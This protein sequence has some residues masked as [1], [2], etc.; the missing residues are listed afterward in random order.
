MAGPQSNARLRADAGSPTSG[1]IHLRTRLTADF[2]VIA[3]ALAQRRGSA[4]T[5]GV[6]AYILSLPDGAPVS[7]AA[8]CRHFTEGEI[9]ISRALREL[10]AAGYLERRRER[11][12]GGVIRTRTFFNDVPGDAEVS[13]VPG[14]GAL[15]RSR[16]VHPTPPTRSAPPPAARTPATRSTRFTQSTRSAQPP[17][18]SAPGPGP[19]PAV[20]PEPVD[21]PD[22]SLSH[23]APDPTPAAREREPLREREPAPESEPAP[24][25]D[26]VSRTDPRALVIL[27]SLRIRDPRLILSRREVD[28]LAPAVSLW[29]ARGVGQKEITDLLT[30]GLPDRFRARP[31]R[32][33]A[34]RLDDPPVAAPPPSTVVPDA[35]AK[36][37]VLPWQTCDG[38]CERAFRAAEPGCCRDCRSESVSPRAAFRGPLPTAC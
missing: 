23:P 4:V 33:L 2:T 35:P 8:L 1:V 5:V 37:V 14:R 19:V 26:P 34:Y 21:T 9:L 30:T 28:R 12:P 3:N 7:I 20:P 13:D 18:P 15:S 24:E 29:L 31:A 27:A 6:A 10:E 16:P 17:T 11:G 36:P 32:I 38:G 22:P 25:Q